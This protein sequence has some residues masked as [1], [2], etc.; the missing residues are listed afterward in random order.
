MRRIEGKEALIKV[1][2]EGGELNL[3]LGT[4]ML[5][6]LASSPGISEN[7]LVTFSKNFDFKAMELLRK[8]LAAE[9]KSE[10]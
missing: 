7:E 1:G 5:F 4:G 3:W 10:K 8:E 9:K 2:K 6:K